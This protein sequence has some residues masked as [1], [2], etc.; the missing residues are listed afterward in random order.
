MLRSRFSLVFALM[1]LLLVA[2]SGV[3]AQDMQYTQ[4]PML[5]SLVESGE[6][7][8]VAER[9]PLEPLVVE[10][11]SE[12]GVHGGTMRFAEAN[13]SMW[14][15]STLRQAG[16]FQYD[17]NNVEITVDMAKD[18][19]FNDDLSALTI[20]LREGLKWSDGA[21]LTTEDIL[22]WWEDVANN[23][24]LSP[25]G[26]GSFWTFEEGPVVFE[27]AGPYEL[28]IQFP[29]P[30]PI[31]LDRL[32]RTYFSS[33]PQ[34]FAPKH[35]LQQWHADYSDEAA[36]LA[37]EEGFEDWTQAFRA[38]LSPARWYEP[39]R[40]WVWRWIPVEETTDRTIYRR[41][42]Y[43]HAVDP[44]G[45][46]LPYIDEVSVSLISD[47]QTMTLRASSGDL[48][49]EAYYLNAADLAVYR[50]GEEAGNYKTLIAGQ[51]RPSDLTLMPNRNVQ[52]PVLNELFNSRDFRI[53]LSVGIDRDRMN[54]ALYF[55]LGRPYPGLPLPENPY[56]PEEWTTLHI[57]HDPDQA[58]A[59]LDGLGL[60]ERDADG[61]RLRSDGERL[62]VLIQIGVLEGNKQAACELVADD[63]VAIG[64]EVVCQLLENSLF[65]ER[66]LANELEIA[67]WHLD[68]GGRFGRSNPLFWAFEDPTQQRWA[69]MWA[70]WISTDGSEGIEPPQEIKDLNDL[71]VQW[72]GTEFGSDEYVQ[73]G[74][75]YFEYFAN[76]VPMIGTVGFWPQPVVVSN[77]LHNVPTE[78][79]YWGSDS[80]FYPPYHPEQWYIQE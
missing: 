3:S 65:N 74:Q 8:P 72:Q 9:L 40:P 18:F 57:E 56:I 49:F 6:L 31:I 52:D 5:D 1:L 36:S 80:N 73:L 64:I 60:T 44:E 27:A 59:L 42:P 24:E 41:N 32:G 17:M 66:N 58:N 28:T 7:P 63:Y 21:P 4:S 25:N 34:L 76:E 50:G 78:N 53:A 13:A 54:E 51:L 30:Y 70:T 22:F 23:E 12:I 33:D 15:A 71:F 79:L 29:K 61:F 10:P 39:D 35:Y 37:E 20:V 38:H 14:S 47:Q 67:T 77:R 45:N 68:R 69:P 75:Q 43:Y 55:G 26:P 11:V 16:L 48:D 19:Y 2:L 46:Q 62:S